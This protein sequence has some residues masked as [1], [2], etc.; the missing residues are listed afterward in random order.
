MPTTQWGRKETIIWPPHSPIYSYGAIFLSIVAAGL[1]V[2]LR[3]SFALTPLEQFYLP[4]YLRT[5]VAGMMHKTDK[6][7]LLTVT[8]GQNHARPATEDDVEEGT[9]PDTGGKHLPLQLS[10]K[11]RAAGF[12]SL[13][14]GPQISYFNKPLNTYFQH[15]VFDGDSLW[16]IFRMPLSFGFLALAFQLPFSIAKDIKRRRQMKYGRRLKGP[17]LLTPKDF[18]KVVEGDGIGFK[19][20]ESEKMMRIPQ[21]A[22]GQHIELMGDTGAGKTTLIMQILRQ[23]QSRGHSAIIYDPACEFVQ[24][25]YDSDRG[26][27]ILNPLDARCPYWGPAEELR[28]KAEAKAIAA[29][30]YQPTTDKKGEFFVE[31][32]Q[33]IFAHLLTFGPSPQELVTWMANP[34]E[35]DRRVQG[36]EMAMMIAKGAQQQRNGVLASLGLIADSLRMLPRKEHA[37]RSWS[38]TEWA[39]ERQGWIF[40]TS[41]P[42]EREALRPLHSLWIDLL[43]LRLLNAP[44]EDQHPVW[45]V[46]DELASL[47]RLPQL[48]TAIT[49][50]RKSRNPLVLGFQGK[51]QL[52][53]IYGHIAEVMLSQPATKIFLKTTEPK[54]AE[55]VS[56]A[57]GKVEIERMRETHFD[58]SRS[59]KNFSLDRQTEPLVMDSEIS[60]LEDKHAFL[61]LGNHVARFSF[62]YSD[63]PRTQKAFVPRPLEDDELAFDPKTLKAK[64]ADLGK[65]IEEAGA[66]TLEDEAVMQSGEHDDTPEDEDERVQPG[67]GQFDRSGF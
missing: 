54:A 41:Q 14:R 9:T 23:I 6:Y 3:F 62:L 66:D 58:G 15:A 12:Q 36:T 25:F 49:E 8:D 37:E 17:V 26:D 59:G 24:R 63:L 50:N 2:Y 11:A 65:P 18:N 40:I 55:W 57:I 31:T 56:N 43:V 42:S 4:Y 7:Q 16:T 27:I 48:H 44:T 61:K 20:V 34:D 39:R 64:Q 51:A 30:L 45:F 35:I 46:L 10:P 5:A 67:Y 47:Q 52:E 21:R 38:A 32:P 22:E 19:T 60:G 33:K 28:R 13:Y 29:S 1:F 53:V